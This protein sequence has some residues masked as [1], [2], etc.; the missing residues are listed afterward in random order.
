MDQLHGLALDGLD[1]VGMTMPQHIDGN[2][3]DEIEV[4]SP[5]QIVDLRPSP[6][7]DRD[8]LATIGLHEIFVGIVSQVLAR[9]DDVSP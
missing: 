4:L 3:T 1:Q 2:P 8:W 6:P 7:H 5:F 9:H